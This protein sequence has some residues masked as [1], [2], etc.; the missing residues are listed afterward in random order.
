MP[1][2]LDLSFAS[3]PPIDPQVGDLEAA[4]R[5]KGW[6]NAEELAAYLRCDDRRVR[7]LASQSDLIVAGPGRPGYCHIADI[8]REEYERCRAA[9]RS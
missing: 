9:M 4:L 6:L 5:G 7:R 1:E 8:T 3:E 2:Q